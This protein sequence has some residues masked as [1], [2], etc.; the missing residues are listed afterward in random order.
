MRPSPRATTLTRL[1]RCLCACLASSPA[2]A[3]RPVSAVR[4]VHAKLAPDAARRRTIVVGDV[5]GCLDELRD[6]LAEC[7]YE[8][9][10][11]RVVLVGDL[12][13]KGP[14]SAECVRFVRTEGFGCVRGNHDDVAL[15]AWERRAK[16]R[17]RGEPPGDA[18]YAYTDDFSA[19]DVKFLR[20]L[21]YTLTL[22]SE[23][24]LVVHAG[25]VPGVPLAAQS[26]EAMYTVRNLLETGAAAAGARWDPTAAAGGVPWAAEWRPDEAAAPGISHVIFGH[27]AKRGLQQHPFTT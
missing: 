11:D 2:R 16:A 8:P 7:E 27:D 26:L 12:V 17:Q 13:N 4:V 10:T 25:L 18:R 20:E 5:H 21:P 1:A 3:A 6:L 22:V 9:A 15:F 14:Q 19:A 24:A 23:G